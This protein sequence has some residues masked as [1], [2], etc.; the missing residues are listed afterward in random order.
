MALVTAAMVRAQ[1]PALSGTEDDAVL[2][3]L[4]QATETSYAARCGYPPTSRGVGSS[5]QSRSYTLDLTGDGGRLLDLEVYPVAS[6]T[7]IKQDETG[8]WDDPD[9]VL[10]ADYS[11]VD[12]SHARLKSTA[13]SSWSQVEGA[14]R[15]T[16]IA[17]YG[18]SSTVTGA[19]TSSATT[20]TVASTAAFTRDANG[21][22]RV[23]IGDEV[24][25]FTGTTATTLTGCTRGA[26]GST[27]AS[28]SDGATVQEPIPP[29]LAQLIVEGVRYRWDLRS[30]ANLQSSTQGGS[31]QQHVVAEDAW[32]DQ[33]LA[34]LGDWML[35]RAVLG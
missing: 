25:A 2:T 11:L 18:G 31:T 34:A 24:I 22:G 14:N 16:F 17:G 6:I 30:T 4:I 33:I 1:I 29:G 15:A 21:G 23:Q 12:G 3:T 19:H 8:D 13:S 10:A 5:M 20:I 27:A 9:T 26:D 28:I 32:P 7:S 35:P